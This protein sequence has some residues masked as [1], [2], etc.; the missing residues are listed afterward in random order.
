MV[1]RRNERCMKHKWRVKG[2]KNCVIGELGKFARLCLAALRHS[3]IKVLID[4]GQKFNRGGRF[5]R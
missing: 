1:K 2:R 3:C 4:L 5:V